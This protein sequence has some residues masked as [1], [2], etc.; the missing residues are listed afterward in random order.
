MKRKIL[1]LAFAGMMMAAC[2]NAGEKKD[3]GQASGGRNSN[4]SEVTDEKTSDP[5]RIVSKSAPAE[6]IINAYLLLKNNFTQDEASMAAKSAN[7]LKTAFTDF[8]VESLQENQSKIFNDIKED[9]V[10]NAEHIAENAGNIEHQ[11]EHFEI[12]SGDIYDLVKAFGT[13]QTLYKVF[14]PMYNNGKGA[15]WLSETKEI[16]NPYFGKSM[17]TCGTV[18]E[19]LK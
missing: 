19:K 6:E 13:G 10:E 5:D 16:K 8:N 12:L 17:P 18:Q 4:V 1:W 3:V 2:Q 14:C 15:F 9:V 7:Q 11:R